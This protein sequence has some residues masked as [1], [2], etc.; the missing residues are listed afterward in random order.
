VPSRD[1]CLIIDDSY[2]VKENYLY[3]RD[4]YGRAGW[5]LE[6]SGFD[7]DGTRLRVHPNAMGKMLVPELLINPLLWFKMNQKGYP[8]IHAAGVTSNGKACIFAGQGAAGKSTIAL[9]MVAKGYKLLSDHFLILNKEQVLRF[10]AP[11]HLTDFNIS[12]FVKSN[13][14]AKQKNLFMLSQ[15]FHKATGKRIAVKISPRNLFPEQIEDKASLHAVFF[16]LL[17]RGT[18]KI[19]AISKEEFIEHMVA[20]QRLESLPFIRYMLEY[21]YIF[22]ESSVASYWERFRQNLNQSL[23]SAA[24]FYRLEVPLSYSDETLNQI[25]EFVQGV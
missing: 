25:R 12:P 14:K 19:E 5:E 11:L 23:G 13:M 6:I 16:L 21:S 22:P 10:P 3:C 1:N 18:L 9:S 8:V 24:C 17:P 2:F 4:S 7:A 20:N 15:L